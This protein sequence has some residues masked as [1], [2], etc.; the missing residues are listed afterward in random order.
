[1]HRKHSGLS[2]YGL[3]AYEREMT[4]PPTLLRSMAL[5]YL[6]IYRRQFGGVH[7]LKYNYNNFYSSYSV[8]KG[9][10][11]YHVN[12]HYSINSTYQSVLNN[13]QN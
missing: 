13:S 1:M 6:Y 5:L 11:L 12:K 3:T 9:D 2:T 7:V 10:Y 8:N 4:T